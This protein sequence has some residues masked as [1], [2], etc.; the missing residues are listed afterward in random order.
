ML[1]KNFWKC[2]YFLLIKI[3]KMFLISINNALCESMTE[4]LGSLTLNHLSLAVDSNPTRDLYPDS[5]KNVDGST[6]VPDVFLHLLSWK[7]LS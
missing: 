5:L 6:Q 1:L 2:K 7:M 3:D 4:L